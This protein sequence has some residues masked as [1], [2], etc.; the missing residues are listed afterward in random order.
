MQTKLT[1]IAELAKQDR[2]LRFTSLAHLLDQQTL[3]ECHQK[4][5]RDKATGV[6][7]TTKAEYE[8]NLEERLEDLVARLKRKGYRPQPSRRTYIPKDEKSVRPLGIPSYEDKIV[9]KG[10]QQIL[11]AIYEQ[12]FLEVSYGFRPGRG[13]HMALQEVDRMLMTEPIRFVVDADIRG[14]FNHVD[15]DWLMR[16]LEQRIADPSL[17]RLIRKFLKAGIMEQGVWEETEEGTPQGGLIS[18]ILGNVYLHYVLDLWFEIEVKK[19]S[20]GKASMVRFADDFVCGFQYL[21]DAERFY[22]ELVER[23][24]KFGLQIAEEKTKIIR[25]G[26]GSEIACKQV[27]LRK[28]A[29][30]DFLGFTHYWGKGK[31]G[32]YRLKRQTSVKKFRTKVKEFNEWMRANRHEK[33]AELAKGIARKLNGHYNYYGVS[34]NYRHLQMYY[35][36]VLTLMK[37]WRNRRSQK[38]NLTWEK[39]DR[40]L[41]RHPL[42]RPRIQVNLYASRAVR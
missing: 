6:D 41:E 29:T 11:N 35:G 21:E 23:L 5:P 19:G 7:G 26:I 2:K 32:K 4:L 42:P 12:D 10:I 17:L 15:H 28:P 20:R 14:F 13:Q 30:F 27:G 3:K 40:F 36:K 22:T 34:D 24:G 1:R 8:E 31:K 18:P 37:K 25:L 33:E 9:Q 38:R 39:V 16:F